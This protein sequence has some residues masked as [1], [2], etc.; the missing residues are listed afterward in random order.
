MNRDVCWDAAVHIVWDGQAKNL[1][2]WK[3]ARQARLL[4]GFP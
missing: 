4:G 2:L 3:D 1:N